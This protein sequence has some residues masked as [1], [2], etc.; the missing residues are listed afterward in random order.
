PSVSREHARLVHTTDGWFVENLSTKNSLR[1]EGREVGPAG[2]AA[3]APGELLQ[4]GRSTLQLLA[5]RR[6]TTWAQ[7]AHGL[8]QVIDEAGGATQAMDDEGIHPLDE[9]TATGVS[10][11]GLFGPGVTLQ[12]AL[13]GRFSRS[14]RWA[15]GIVAVLLF[16]VSSVITLGTAAL[17]GHS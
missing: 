7:P 6:H 17:V 14:T 16:V 12:F 13:T 9:D 10:A 15:L 3:V 11:T 1:V 5:P 4:L 8:E 2:R